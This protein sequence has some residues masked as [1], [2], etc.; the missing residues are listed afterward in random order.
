[1]KYTLLYAMMLVIVT[2][3]CAAPKFT[4]LTPPEPSIVWPKPPD[5]A[6]IRYLGELKGSGDL[7]PQKNASEFWNEI[8]HGPIQPSSLVSPHAVAV[9]ADGSRVAVADTTAGAV[10]IFDLERQVYE[11]KLLECPVAVVWI[12][13]RLLVADSKRHAVA[14]LEVD[15]QTKW[16]GTDILKRPSGIAFCDKNNLCYVS[17]AGA[18]AVLAFDRGGNLVFQFGTHGGGPGQFNCPSQIACAPDGTLAVVDSL[19]F[20]VQ[21]FDLDGT[22]LSTFGSKGDAAGDLALPKGVSSGPS[23]NLWVVDAHFENIQVFMPDGT[24]LLAFGKEGHGPG[25]FWLP[26][27]ICID[28]RNRMWV[29]DTYNQRV[30]VFELMQ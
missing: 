26:A 25:E 8:V 17:D 14:E 9:H 2:A 3:G 22:P 16:F 23:G 28:M 7:H 27:G 30:Q 13:D 6:R 15:G 19:N 24:L 18:H 5:T 4:L 21:R 20:R 11:R 1:M 29:A 12:N 10:H